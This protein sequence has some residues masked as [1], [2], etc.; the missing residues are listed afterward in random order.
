MSSPDPE[1]N[2]RIQRRFIRN[3]VKPYAMDPFIESQPYNDPIQT[4]E[5]AEIFAESEF[6]L[7]TYKIDGPV[8]NRSSVDTL[9]YEIPSSLNFDSIS[10]KIIQKLHDNIPTK[11]DPFT[12][13]YLIIITLL[14][15]GNLLLL[16]L[17]FQKK[18]MK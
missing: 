8:E 9:S 12:I 10:D 14:S 2:E 17:L 4:P 16:K 5:K 1:F 7:P 3:V 18:K 11:S 13:V 15:I 6:D